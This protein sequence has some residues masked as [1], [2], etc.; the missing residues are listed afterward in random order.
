MKYFG[1][2][3][4]TYSITEKCEGEFYAARQLMRS[5][6]QISLWAWNLI[7]SFVVCYV[8]KGPAKNWPLIERS[9]TGCVCLTVYDLQT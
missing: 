8:S 3:Y 1:Y 6:V 9:P 4:Y 2:T 7:S 5:R